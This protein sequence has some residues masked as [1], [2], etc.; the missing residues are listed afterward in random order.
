MT[1]LS[2]EVREALAVLGHTHRAMAYAGDD[3]S[4][5]AVALFEAALVAAVEAAQLQ[6]LGALSDAEIVE[7]A[8][9]MM[10]DIAKETED[11]S[12]T[13]TRYVP[14]DDLDETFNEDRRDWFR[15]R[16]RATLPILQAPLRAEIERLKALLATERFRADNLCTLEIE[17]LSHTLT[18]VREL[19]DRAESRAQSAERER[20]ETM[21][22]NRSV[23]VCASH[24]TEVVGEGCLVCDCNVLVA[25]VKRLRERDGEIRTLIIAATQAQETWDKTIDNLCR[26]VTQ[27]A[28]TTAKRGTPHV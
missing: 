14:W 5:G 7:A 4:R 11:V 3:A 13:V 19:R 26:A 22:S 17:Q 6:R 18:S 2:N 16:A 9:K 28:Q 8:A 21:A 1:D 20:D 23:A 24:T 10:Y 12:T 15:D 25:E 27:E